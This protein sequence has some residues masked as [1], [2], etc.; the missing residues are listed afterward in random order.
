MVWVAVE[1]LVAVVATEGDLA[2]WWGE[3][4]ALAGQGGEF[5]GADVE[6]DALEEEAIGVE[7]GAVGFAPCVEDGGE[8]VAGGG[9]GE[10][11]DGGL[12]VVGFL[13]VGLEEGNGLV[14]E[15]RKDD[16]FNVAL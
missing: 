14:A 11:E 10:G 8:E 4:G 2:G 1:G 3:I 15:T 13:E 16:S 6:V 5:G 7:G 9:V 12:Q